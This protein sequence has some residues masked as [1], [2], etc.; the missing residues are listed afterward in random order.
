MNT[1][2]LADNQYI[3]HEGLISLL[4]RQSGMEGIV[5]AGSCREL[6]LQLKIFPCA[7]VVVDYTLFDFSS[8][9]H[10][11]NMKSGAKESSWLLF[12]D[13]LGEAFLRQALLADPTISVVM[14]HDRAEQII[15]ALRA[16]INMTFRYL[17]TTI[18]PLYMIPGIL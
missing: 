11:L 14:K 18:L 10:F 6:S 2:I 9:H 7:V 15:E 13:E 3:T 4:H 16:I 5:T 12:S 8:V 1:Y 17:P